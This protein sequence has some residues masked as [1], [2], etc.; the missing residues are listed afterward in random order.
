MSQTAEPLSNRLGALLEFMTEEK[1]KPLAYLIETA[2]V[3]RERMI[4]WSN[5]RIE[6]F[7][8]EAYLGLD[9]LATLKD[10]GMASL[11]LNDLKD[12]LG[13]ERS[14][15]F[16]TQFEPKL[17]TAPTA[18]DAKPAGN[19][20]AITPA[21][22]A[23]IAG[24]LAVLGAVIWALI[25]FAEFV[26]GASFLVA[27]LCGGI[28]LLLLK[29]HQSG[30]LNPVGKTTLRYSLVIGGA[31]VFL[32]FATDPFCSPSR[33]LLD[34]GGKKSAFEAAEQ[35][36]ARAKAEAEAAAERKRD[37]AAEA[38]NPAP[39]REVA[40]SAEET[41]QQARK[42]VI[43]TSCIGAI[44]NGLSKDEMWVQIGRCTRLADQIQ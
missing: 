1:G 23:I 8:T 31:A 2:G 40:D 4:R 30:G 17:R 25:A 14:R 12:V 28:L 29:A 33:M 19:K 16:Y 15:D 20:D 9:V 36:K 5:R 11:Y 35:A 3:K 26:R 43:F 22:W 44:P 41:P 34:W 37:E 32:I 42:R 18:A 10:R 6:T 24:G 27:C 13:A 7:L 38:A 21:E 39:S